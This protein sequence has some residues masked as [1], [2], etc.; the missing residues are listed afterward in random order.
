MTQETSARPASRLGRTLLPLGLLFLSVGVSVALFNPFLSL[1]LST[2]VDAGPI[3]ITIFLIVAPLGGVLASSIIGRFS[4]RRPIRRALLISGAAAGVFGTGVTA[5][6]RDYWVLLAL[7]V[8]A[9]AIA[10]S[11]FPQSFAY[12]RQVLERDDPARA[13]M[14]ISALRTVFS[15]AWVAGP[16]LGAFLL[17]TGGFVWIYGTAAL[18]YALAALVAVF[19][20]DEVPARAH[21]ASDDPADRPVDAG[22]WTLWLTA[23]AFTLLQTPLTLAVQALPLFIGTELQGDVGDAGL[24]LGLCAALEIPLMLGLGMLAVRVPLRR[25]LFAGAA[26]G[27][28][29]Y[30]VAATA[31]GL[32]ALVAGQALNA[33]FIAAVTGLGISYMQNMLPGHPGR[34]TTLFTNGFPLGAML[35][36]PLFGLAQHFDYRLA[37]WLC[38]ALCAAGL[39]LLIVVRNDRPTRHA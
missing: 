30:T 39:L 14:G 36:G 26:C 2:E 29:Y 22:R 16:P 4:D 15:L 7:S 13:P 25:L 19:W 20:L 1:F 10:G 31:T 9:F 12:A 11:L 34:A 8:T 24:L 35:A 38:T 17:A 5:V 3:K 18:M 37:Y 32:G 23:A 6:V 27:I 28:A 21:R 33:M